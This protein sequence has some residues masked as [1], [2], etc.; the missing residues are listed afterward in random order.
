MAAWIERDV[1]GWGRRE[2]FAAW[3]LLRSPL[4]QVRL[5]RMLE[6]DRPEFY[7]SHPRHFISIMLWG[8]YLEEREGLPSRWRHAGGIA[9]RPRDG[10]HAAWHP[11]GKASW[12]L[13]FFL[14]HKRPWFKA[15][16]ATDSSRG[17]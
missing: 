14:G 16:F 15:H 1:K 4:L 11:H 2:Q 3:H 12:S 8:R 10:Y 6:P 9:W 5:H 17:C 7:H 13:V